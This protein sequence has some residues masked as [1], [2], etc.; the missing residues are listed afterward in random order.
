MGSIIRKLSNARRFERSSDP[1][2]WAEEIERRIDQRSLTSIF[3]FFMC[4]A[5]AWFVYDLRRE[6]AALKADI[7]A[8]AGPQPCE[9][10]PGPSGELPPP[11]FC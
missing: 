9:Q 5:L 11:G 2:Q 3:A 7:Q 8:I 10:T 1:H 4:I 6:Q